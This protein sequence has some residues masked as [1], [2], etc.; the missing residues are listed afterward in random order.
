MDFRHVAGGE[1][2]ALLLASRS[3]LILSDEARYEWEH[4][5]A[6]RKTDR[7]NGRVLVRGRR[8]SVTFRVMKIPSS[9]A[10]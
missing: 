10:E 6:R 2:E 3:L 9:R 5:I 4:G 7:W 1:R 8:L